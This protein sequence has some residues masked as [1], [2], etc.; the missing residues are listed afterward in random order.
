MGDQK[1]IIA[2]SILITIPVA[3]MFALIFYAAGGFYIFEAMFGTLSPGFRIEAPSTSVFSGRYSAGFMSML[4]GVAILAFISIFVFYI[5]G[6]FRAVANNM[7]NFFLKKYRVST[8]HESLIEKVVIITFSPVVVI[9]LVLPPVIIYY[10]IIGAIVAVIISIIGIVLWN[11]DDF[12]SEK[13]RQWSWKIII[14]L[15]YGV[16]VP[17]F[18]YY[19]VQERNELDLNAEKFCVCIKEGGDIKG[20]F[21]MYPSDTL[22][23]DYTK[24]QRYIKNLAVGCY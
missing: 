21:D 12:K 2:L 20:C 4:F 16:G 14:G 17:F 11:V 1:K 10:G 23:T 9:S 6:K 3:M 19:L 7:C 24:Q 15:V 5:A 8:E 13:V 18:I 22:Y